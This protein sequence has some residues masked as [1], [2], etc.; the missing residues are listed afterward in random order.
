MST[1]EIAM[2]KMLMTDTFEPTDGGTKWTLI[3]EYE[4]PYSLLGKLIDKLKFRK[5]IEKGSDYYVNKTKELIEK[6]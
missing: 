5:D 2:K 6:E 1:E 3:L 4:L